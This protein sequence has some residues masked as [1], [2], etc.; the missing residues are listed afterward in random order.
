MEK[1]RRILEYLDA[2][3]GN[4]GTDA[5]ED[6]LKHDDALYSEFLAVKESLARFDALAEVEPDNGYFESVVPRFRE[7]LEAK[8][9]RRVAPLFW[10]LGGAVAVPALAVTLFITQPWQVESPDPLVKTPVKE[11][12][13]A[14]EEPK[15]VNKETSP[16]TAPVTRVAKAV[17]VRQQLFIDSDKEELLLNSEDLTGDG[18]LISSHNKFETVYSSLL[19]LDK[20]TLAEAVDK[21]GFSNEE[22]AQNLSEEDIQ[23]LSETLTPVSN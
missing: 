22:I 3:Q 11:S 14:K 23:K 15:T 5:F 12:V 16:A 18:S 8:R 13:L 4:T 17:P 7:R 20:A 2:R 6:D 10:K 9:S 1:K 21:Y 19:G